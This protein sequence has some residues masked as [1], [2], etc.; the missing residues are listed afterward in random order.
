MGM[1]MVMVK[2]ME[3]VENGRSGLVGEGLLRRRRELV[4]EEK[5]SSWFLLLYVCVF[6]VTWKGFSFGLWI[7]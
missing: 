7:L 5:V 3:M 4:D 1:V 2:V 6:S